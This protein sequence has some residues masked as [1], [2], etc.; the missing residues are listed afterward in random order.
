MKINQYEFPKTL[1]ET[2]AFFKLP[3]VWWY[4][5]DNVGMSSEEGILSLG[6]TMLD[7]TNK[8]SA[9]RKW[10]EEE[11]CIFNEQFMIMFIN[12]YI[13]NIED[14][15]IKFHTLMYQKA[16]SQLDPT[17]ILKLRSLKLKRIIKKYGK[18]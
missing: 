18:N 4:L 13:K 16:M 9:L 12:D 11:L 17:Y 14:F 7:L 3:K 10:F 2:A 1:F 6:I 5:N 15:D 8:N